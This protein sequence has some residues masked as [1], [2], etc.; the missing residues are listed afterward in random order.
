MSQSLGKGREWP[1]FFSLHKSR[2]PASRRVLNQCWYIL[3]LDAKA[4][5]LK[6]GP[7]GILEATSDR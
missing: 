3:C 5:K 1:F 7:R 4:G 6:A 2:V